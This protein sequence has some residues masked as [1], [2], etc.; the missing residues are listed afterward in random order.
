MTSWTAHPEKR[1]ACY[2]RSPCEDNNNNHHD[3]DDND[4]HKNLDPIDTVGFCFT[5]AATAG[6]TRRFDI[7][8]ASVRCS[9]DQHI[10]SI[11]VI[12]I[13]LDRTTIMV[14]RMEEAW[15]G[16]QGACGR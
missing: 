2:F 6:S 3:N 13:V 15:L 16:S 8:T 7:Y 10:G 11:V 4:N 1:R 5:T 9:L 14:R 12:L